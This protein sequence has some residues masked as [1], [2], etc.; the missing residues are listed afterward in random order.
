M[1]RASFRSTSVTALAI[2]LTARLDPDESINN[3][4]IGV[5]GGSRSEPG[6]SNVAPL[7]PISF[8]SKGSDLRI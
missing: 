8:V 6:G 2:T 5:R 4:V 7:T 1:P 3:G